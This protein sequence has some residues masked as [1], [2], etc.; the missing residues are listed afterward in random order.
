MLAGEGLQAHEVSSRSAEELTVTC[1]SLD[2]VEAS[3]LSDCGPGGQAALRVHSAFEGF[4]LSAMAFLELFDESV[5]AKESKYLR[6]IGNLFA[7]RDM[8]DAFDQRSQFSWR[9][10]KLFEND[11][12]EACK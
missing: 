4:H 12:G 9:P 8:G 1:S 2:Y 5:S 11:A 6:Q 3:L 7:P 10:K